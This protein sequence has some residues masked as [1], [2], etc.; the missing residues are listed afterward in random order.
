MF[1]TIRIWNLHFGDYR[2]GEPKY[3]EAEC[4][5]RDT[6]FFVPLYVQVKLVNR[7]TGEIQE[8]EVFMGDFPQMTA[9]GTFIYNGAERVVVS[10]LIRSPGV[11]FTADEDR[12]T[13]RRLCSAKLIPNRGA[14]LEME[15]SKRDIISVKVDRKRKLPVTILLRAMGYATD[16]EILDLFAD[17]DNVPE[18]Q[19]ILTHHG[20]RRPRQAHA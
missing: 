7:E 16:E 14:W 20:K 2:F 6:T 19:Y 9:N 5:E 4:R 17:D 1:P 10:Q 13:G 3:P 15:T 8:Q 18:H 11:Y 12:Q